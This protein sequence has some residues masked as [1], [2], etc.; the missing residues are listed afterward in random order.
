MFDFILNTFPIQ[1][2]RTCEQRCEAENIQQKNPEKSVI[3][4]NKLK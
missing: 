4:C 1:Q 3:V 2:C